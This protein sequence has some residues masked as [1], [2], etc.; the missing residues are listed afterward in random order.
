MTIREL[1]NALSEIPIER[2]DKQIRIYVDCPLSG[3][4]GIATLDV[5]QDEGFI[6][7]CSVPIREKL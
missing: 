1:S 2:Q 4:L 5:D 6:N 7:V 3:Y